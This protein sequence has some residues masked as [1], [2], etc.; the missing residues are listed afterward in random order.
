MP[1][2]AYVQVDTV[3]IP[4]AIIGSTAIDLLVNKCELV[5]GATCGPVAM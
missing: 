3:Q 5:P 1:T 2:E 4:G